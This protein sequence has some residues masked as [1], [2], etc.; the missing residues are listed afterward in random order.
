MIYNKKIKKVFVSIPMKGKSIKEIKEDIN[1]KYDKIKE[2]VNEPFEIIDSVIE[3]EYDSPIMYLAKS[4]EILSTAD[5]AYFCKGWESAN[6]CTIER[7]CCE[8]YDIPII[9][10]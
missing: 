4:L 3:E 6:G 8:K 1:S 10:E 7:L 2:K 5:L 9:E